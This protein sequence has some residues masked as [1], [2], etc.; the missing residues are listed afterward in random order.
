MSIYFSY[1]PNIAG[2]KTVPITKDIVR[3]KRLKYVD[4]TSSVR[5]YEDKQGNQYG[6]FISND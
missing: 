1:Y 5:L 4:K 3:K 2:K 6:V